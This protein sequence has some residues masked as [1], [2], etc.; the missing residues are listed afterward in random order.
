VLRLKE[1]EVIEVVFKNYLRFPCNFYVHGLQ[2]VDGFAHG[3]KA[4]KPGEQVT[5]RW[6]ATAQSVP[7][8]ADRDTIAFTYESASGVDGSSV[9]DFADINAGLHGAALVSRS[10]TSPFGGRELI[11][12]MSVTDENKSPYLDLNLRK[13]AMNGYSTNKQDPVYKES[14]RMHHI[15]GFMFCN[16]PG[17]NSPQSRTTRLF[18]LGTGPEKSIFAPRLSGT[19]FNLDGT[20]L[21]TTE[22]LSGSSK[23]V[24]FEHSQWGWWLFQDQVRDHARAGM[25]ALFH[26]TATIAQ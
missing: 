3:Y 14:N 13:F 24:E 11:A 22:M 12:F 2:P 25:A 18:L 10:E 5:Y 9:S 17:F 4:V 16:L 15:N 1:G 23:V 19:A 6:K 21:S 7:L 26:C 20:H 8:T